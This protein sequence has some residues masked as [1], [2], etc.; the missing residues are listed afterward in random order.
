MGF[1]FCSFALYTFF[2]SVSGR[3]Q[4]FRIEDSV[5]ATCMAYHQNPNTLRR[6][7]THDPESRCIFPFLCQPIPPNS[8]TGFVSWCESITWIRSVSPEWYICFRRIATQ[9][10]GPIGFLDA[11]TLWGNS[12]AATIAVLWTPWGKLHTFSDETFKPCTVSV[13]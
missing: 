11:P 12:A 8:E 10:R 2:T 13:V 7:Y 5:F 6:Q 3:V 9:Y 1:Q 4:T